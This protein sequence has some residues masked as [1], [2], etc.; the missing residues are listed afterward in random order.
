MIFISRVEAKGEVTAEVKTCRC[1]I[2]L[3]ITPSMQDVMIESS[4]G[5]EVV[6]GPGVSI[7]MCCTHV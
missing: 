3:K 1:N 4:T 7:V 5:E 6:L 2:T